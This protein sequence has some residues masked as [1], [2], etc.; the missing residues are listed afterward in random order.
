MFD[1][2]LDACHAATDLVVVTLHM[3][4]RIAGFGQPQA[5]FFNRGIAG[6]TL[7]QTALLTNF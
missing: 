3:I 7:R 6:V 4:Q 5:I 1:R 2:L